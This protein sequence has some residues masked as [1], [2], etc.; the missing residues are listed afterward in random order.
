VSR[1]VDTLGQG[2]GRFL[3][4]VARGLQASLAKPVTAPPAGPELTFMVE[5]VDEDLSA[6]HQAPTQ[7]LAPSPTVAAERR[8]LQ[9]AGEFDAAGKHVNRTYRA[10][11]DGPG[12]A[13]VPVSV[14]RFLKAETIPSG[15]EGP[16]WGA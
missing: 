1:A 5:L 2:L 12:G 6:E 13:L 16:K 3:G 11:I 14:V 8:A 10:R 4:S 9:V 7:V 15:N